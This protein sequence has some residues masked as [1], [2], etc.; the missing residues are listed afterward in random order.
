M[1]FYVFD[2]D[3]TLAN[4]EHRRHFVADGNRQWR[5]FFAECVN[6]APYPNVV[7]TLRDLVS[8]G[9][10]VEVWS[11]RS[12]EVRAESE[13]WLDQHVYSGASKLLTRMRPEKDYQSDVELK[14][15]WLHEEYA[16]G[17]P[18]PTVVFD[19][20]QCVVDMWREE[21]VTCAQVAPGDFDKPKQTVIKSLPTLTV[22]VGPS[23]AG[24]STWIANNRPGSAVVASDE[25][26]RLQFGAGN[27]DAY[28]NKG[29][30]QT[31]GAMHRLVRENLFNGISTVADATHLSRRSRMDLIKALDGIDM[32]VEYVVINRPLVD[33]LASYNPNTHW[34]T[35]PE[36]ITAMDTKFQSTKRDALRGDDMGFTVVDLT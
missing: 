24:K 9:H 6:D 1:T 31:F 32:N 25:I 20:R 2:Y 13:A 8:A 21:G 11:G 33:K 4:V 36:V 30:K 12:D 18:A 27:K 26:R 16:A 5:Q 15:S 10:R 17:N 35:K 7:Q 3:G 14:R 23:G 29:F 22:M 19:D 28:T 34:H